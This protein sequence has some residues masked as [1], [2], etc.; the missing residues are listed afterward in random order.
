MRKNF[1]I[2]VRI[3]E[4]FPNIA[5]FVFDVEPEVGDKIIKSMNTI[6]RLIAM[7]G[8]E[9]VASKIICEFRV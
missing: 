7:S 8:H 3:S 2:G 1:R 5:V 4:I 9:N 6:K